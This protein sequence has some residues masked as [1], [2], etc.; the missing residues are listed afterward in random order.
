VLHL[1][2]Q[3]GY[4]SDDIFVENIVE[5][6]FNSL[7]EEDINF[8][9]GSITFNIYVLGE[10][11]I[12]SSESEKVVQIRLDKPVFEVGGKVIKISESNIHPQ[13]TFNVKVFFENALDSSKVEIAVMTLPAGEN[14]LPEVWK[15]KDGQEITQAGK[16]IFEVTTISDGYI[17][18]IK[19]VEEIV[20]L[21]PAEIDGVKKLI[22]Q[23]G[24]HLFVLLTSV[25]NVAQTEEN[26]NPVLQLIIK[27]E[28]DI[29]NEVFEYID[30]NITNRQGQIEYNNKEMF[31]AMRGNFKVSIMFTG[32]GYLDSKFV[33]INGTR[34]NQNQSLG[35]NNGVLTW[36]RTT[37]N[38][39]T[40]YLL[41][42]HHGAIDEETPAK[43][44]YKHIPDLSII[45]DDLNGIAGQ[46][47]ANIKVLGNM[48]ADE[49]TL[50]NIVLD[51]FFMG[52]V[53]I[54]ADDSLVF[55]EEA[56]SATK[57]YGPK[58]VTI[59]QGMFHINKTDETGRYSI[60]A[61]DSEY[62]GREYNFMTEYEDEEVVQGLS[63]GFY[64]GSYTLQIGQVYTFAIKSLSINS[65]MLNSDAIGEIKVKV[66]DGVTNFDVAW[67]EDGPISRM[68]K[69]SITWASVSG[70]AG[71][72]ITINANSIMQDKLNIVSTNEYILQSNNAL[73]NKSHNFQVRAM[74]SS[75]M[76]GEGVFTLTSRLSSSI[77][78]RGLGMPKVKITNGLL[79][80]DIVQ[81]AEG[82]YIYYMR[83][84]ALGGYI[85]K[86]KFSQ[87]KTWHSEFVTKTSWQV[88]DSF[89]DD[90][91]NMVYYF[92]VVAI[93]TDIS[94]RLMP[95]AY[96]S[97][98]GDLI[99]G[100]TGEIVTENVFYPVTV[101]KA[102][103][104]F[105]NNEGVSVWTGDYNWDFTS[106]M[107]GELKGGTSPFVYGTDIQEMLETL[108]KV[109]VKAESGY[110]FTK[111]IEAIALFDADIL[112][113]ALFKELAADY[114]IDSEQK[115][116]I[117]HIDQFIN[118][119][120]PN[121]KAGNN[122]ISAMQVGDNK[123]WISSKYNVGK[124]IYVPAQ[125]HSTL[126]NNILSWHS[127]DLPNDILPYNSIYKYNIVSE[128]EQGNRILLTRTNDLSIDLMEFVNSE[129]LK[130]GMQKIYVF[131][132]GDSG[133]YVHGIVNQPITTFILPAINARME[134]GRLYW[135]SMQQTNQYIVSAQTDGQYDSF[136]EIMTVNTWDF[137][138]LNARDSEDNSIEY[139]L[140]LQ[141][142]GN[143]KTI[144][145]GRVTRFG[146]IIKLETPEVSIQNGIFTWQ[147]K[148]NNFGYE[149]DVQGD[150]QNI[151][152]LNKN[153][154]E[155][156]SPIKGFN[157]YNFRT[158]GST[159]AAL[160]EG[161]LNYAISS[162]MQN[163]LY[164]VML[165]SVQSIEIDNGRIIWQSVNDLLQNAVES[166][167]LTFDQSNFYA[168]IFLG[169]DDISTQIIN[170]RTYVVYNLPQDYNAGKFII[171]I[172]GLSNQSYT[173]N[174]K[175][176]MYLLSEIESP[177]ST[178]VFEKLQK[179]ENAKSENGVITW[180]DL[181]SSLNTYKLTFV[182][183]AQT[184]EF[185]TD[186]PSFNP[187]DLRGG[188]QLK[189][190]LI[191]AESI[192]NVRV[193]I[194]GN[195]F[196]LINS[197]TLIIAD[198]EKLQDL[199]DF[200]YRLD[201]VN[202]N[203]F[204]IRWYLPV[205]Y[206]TVSNYEYVI[207]YIND[208]QTDQERVLSSLDDPHGYI[209]KGYDS[210]RQRYY[211]EIEASNLLGLG[212]Y[213]LEYRVAIVPIS[214]SPI[215]PSNYSAKS[216]VRP[217]ISLNG[218]FTFNQEKQEISWLYEEEVS[219][220]NFRITDELVEVDENG[221]VT[222]IKTNVYIS[223]SR[224]FYPKE[225]GLHRVKIAVVLLGG[226][227]SSG[228]VYFFQQQ[229]V[230]GLVNHQNFIEETPYGN[231]RFTLIELSLF[232]EGDGSNENPY[233][234]ENQTHFEN[235]NHR[236][237]KP[238]YFGEEQVFYFIQTQ[239]LTALN[240]T[241]EIGNFA[242]NY[243]GQGFEID[244][245]LISSE[246]AQNQEVG[247]FKG[248]ARNG[249]IKNLSIRA[250][251]ILQNAGSVSSVKLSALVVVNNG[252]IENLLIKA[253]DIDS[254]IL[255]S[256]VSYSY[257]SIA[258]Q[259]NTTGYITKAINKANLIIGQMGQTNISNS[260]FTF[261]VGG[262]VENN[263]GILF[264]VGSQANIKIKANRVTI[265]GIAVS[266]QQN[267]VIERAYNTGIF[268]ATYSAANSLPTISYIGGL[269]G[270]NRG[271][272]YS[273]YNKA[274][275]FS[276]NFS[277]AAINTV[278]I[279]GLV[280]SAVGTEGGLISN[281]FTTTTDIVILN[282]NAST[283]QV[284]LLIGNDSSSSHPAQTT[285]YYSNT[286]AHPFIYGES[287]MKCEAIQTLQNLF[288]KLNS[289]DSVFD[290][291][292]N[293][294]KLNWEAE[295]NII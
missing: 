98:Y 146:T 59:N 166:Y 97:I 118:E 278:H 137:S 197:D 87:Y 154:T 24:E 261:T 211:G 177:N 246:T 105:E 17:T 186:T 8:A 185:F 121:I 47:T 57:L 95:S 184:F 122:N 290:F 99:D 40:G 259:N 111:D 236:L 167:K 50:N 144:I 120:F 32:V 161:S 204:M 35:E 225:I 85:D 209:K 64:Q 52:K 228:Y 237:S 250:K 187:T 29:D 72:I 153:I 267:A 67:K 285:N 93:N 12:F 281:S 276:V 133:T 180:D 277:E 213:K 61:L 68:D 274:E 6:N 294:L 195:S 20:K 18:S 258:N 4:K 54:L 280:G 175:N 227:V 81:N 55:D 130:P 189:Y 132:S 2:T 226:N 207:S 239:N 65:N 129:V 33:S 169:K 53:T 94:Y 206:V 217:P 268:E 91:T 164:A 41:N 112:K 123:F 201:E 117:G 193:Q 265:A 231:E 283:V 216:T 128:D 199:V 23:D 140:T 100:E 74:G 163:E 78:L 38:F 170:D 34:L 26:I 264:E 270:I 272:I 232:G 176:Y 56:Y 279:G 200:T 114:G 198:F 243:D 262:I 5:Y 107:K 234:V 254:K 190:E 3:D 75:A 179:A 171:H 77:E 145:S 79:N 188:D 181:N 240:L 36:Q 69:V 28:N 172:Q 194:L 11:N 218:E 235:I 286:V 15:Y 162:K 7:L 30:D 214:A 143:G 230:N 104:V 202:Q 84:D 106:L 16:F 273:S 1:Q 284:G 295:F 90:N 125:V 289:V 71:Y 245:T 22:N 241:K 110:T 222:V 253:F 42:V 291:E 249:V 126:Y 220:V 113:S 124:N 256:M 31:Y 152:W 219:D 251:I 255:T 233:T 101:L 43:L 44:V 247:L 173:F 238:T 13:S 89:G 21:N 58:E 223:K 141:A 292:N 51:S 156:E 127:V 244:Y 46:I 215:I 260:S 83:K 221:I 82:Y 271:A 49:V 148:D 263:Q 183:G 27:I 168:P 182:Q 174:G 229:T 151:I 115:F 60:I 191:T 158:L 210:E 139:N 76:D 80:W 160:E 242:G 66:I 103:D 102:P 252:R 293:V 257:G 109:K 96:G 142:L 131:V 208:D 205:D 203:G 14:T 138:Q 10:G 136:T 157:N 108:I 116:G 282:K 37:Q 224:Q 269:V 70:A 73:S 63:L 159:T 88:P 165:N 92:A 135:D 275:K 248:L 119:I 266:S 86:Y 288:E 150:N 212:S 45:N 48:V 62:Q 25:N 149:I 192:V 196:D 9:Q 39:S 147:N 178:V 287:N 155:Y 134:N 19:T